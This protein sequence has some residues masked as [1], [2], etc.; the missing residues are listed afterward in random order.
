MKAIIITDLECAELVRRLELA[1]MQSEG[2]FR[3]Q[4][5]EDFDKPAT[6]REVHRAFHFVVVR[7]L[8][9]MGWRSS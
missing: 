2:H 9:D 3:N 6:V 4:R 5:S 1:G 7:W 8:Q